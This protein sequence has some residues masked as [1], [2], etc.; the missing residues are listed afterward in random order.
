MAVR[1]K[2]LVTEID[3]GWGALK[4]T[5]EVIKASNG[6]AIVQV[7]FVGAAAD[8][9]HAG[10]QGLTNAELGTVHEFGSPAA[11]IPE[12]SFLRSTFDEGRGEYKE[13]SR[14]LLRAVIERRISVA[15]ALKVLGLKVESDVRARIR[16]GIPP[17]NSPA[18]VAAKG[19]S[20]PLIDTGQ[21]LNAISSQVVIKGQPQ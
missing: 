2:A 9:V 7:G 17:P 20:T 13:L 11:G 15:T 6:G 18:T 19:S 10:A 3:R 12:R 14:K 8:Q 21:M 4:K 16:A 5:L 1:A